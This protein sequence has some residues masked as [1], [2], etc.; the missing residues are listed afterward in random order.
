MRTS[1]GNLNIFMFTILIKVTKTV[2][3][4]HRSHSRRCLIILQITGFSRDLMT[5][6]FGWEG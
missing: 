2:V 5:D 3:N 4:D 6:F 1:F